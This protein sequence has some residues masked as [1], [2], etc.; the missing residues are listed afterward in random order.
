MCLVQSRQPRGPGVIKGPLKTSA[1]LRDL[2]ALQSLRTEDR[3]ADAVPILPVLSQRGRSRAPANPASARK[4]RRL[5]QGTGHCP[6]P[7]SCLCPLPSIHSPHRQR[8][9]LLSNGRIQMFRSPTQ[10]RQMVLQHKPWSSGEHHALSIPDTLIYVMQVTLLSAA[11]WVSRIRAPPALPESPSTS[12][13]PHPVF[14]FSNTFPLS[15]VLA[16]MSLWTSI[17]SLN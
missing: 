16:Y 10:G 1:N 17:P 11:Q 9:L 2:G 15:P 8:E 7:G 13:L 5:A 6:L 12:P 4:P 3:E 14:H